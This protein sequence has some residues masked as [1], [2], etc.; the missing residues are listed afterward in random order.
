[1][2][3]SDERLREMATDESGTTRDKDIHFVDPNNSVIL[4]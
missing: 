2:A 1:V 4:I 3:V